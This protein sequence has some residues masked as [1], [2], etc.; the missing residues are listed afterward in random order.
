MVAK[1]DEQHAAMVALAVDPAR[2]ADGGADIGSAQLG[3]VM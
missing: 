3:A 2:K 1:V